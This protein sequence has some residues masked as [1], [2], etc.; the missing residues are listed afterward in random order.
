MYLWEKIL[1][2]KISSLKWSVF[3]GKQC[4][5]TNGLKTFCYCFAVIPMFLLQ[6]S[7]KILYLVRL[8]RKIGGHEFHHSALLLKTVLDPRKERDGEVVSNW[9]GGY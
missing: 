4:G 1:R 9:T 7:M 6:L 8:V 2:L 5:W 3:D